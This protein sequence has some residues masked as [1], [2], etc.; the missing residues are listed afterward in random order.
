MTPSPQRNFHGKTLMSRDVAGFAFREMV[1]KPGIRIPK[2]SHERA[3]VAFVLRGVF[4]ER[5]ERETLE[6][7][8]LSVSFLAPGLTHSDDFQNG[9]HCFLFEIAPPRLERVREV[10][11]MIDPVFLN[12]GAPAWLMMRLYNEARE[13]DESSSLAAEGL[14][15]EILAALSRERSSAS[16][17]RIPRWLT[18]AKDLLHARF[19]ETLTHELLASAVGVHPVH[20]ASEFRK[21]FKSTIGEYVRRLRIEHASR[22]L[23]TSDASLAEIAVTSGFADQSHFCKVFKRLAGMTPTQFRSNLR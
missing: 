3:H 14:T 7:R 17:L 5:C 12:G 22:Q 10:L 11:P 21:H 2:H 19:P 16:P 8:P 15:L 18:Q 23:A 13:T 6:C 9:A 1:H 20:L 4:T